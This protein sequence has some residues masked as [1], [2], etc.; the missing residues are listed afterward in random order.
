[1][2]KV[3]RRRDS[4]ECSEQR[5]EFITYLLVSYHHRAALSTPSG[6]YIAYLI[7]PFFSVQLKNPLSMNVK[8]TDYPY[9]L[10]A[11]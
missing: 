3:G 1:M 11:S 10:S 8:L 6:M 4:Y 9:I 7:I 5:R 2:D